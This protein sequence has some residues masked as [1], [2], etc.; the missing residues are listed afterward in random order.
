MGVWGID[1]GDW[2]TDSLWTEQEYQ[3]LNFPDTLSLENTYIED[4]T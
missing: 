2:S 4:T 3:I 1:D